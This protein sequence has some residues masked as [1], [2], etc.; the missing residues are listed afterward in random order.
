MKAGRRKINL[1][2]STGNEVPIFRPVRP[3]PVADKPPKEACPPSH[4]GGLKPTLNRC[5]LAWPNMQAITIP[6]SPMCV[7]WV[8]A[9]PY[10]GIPDV[11]VE[12]ESIGRYRTPNVST[13]PTIPSYFLRSDG[14][15]GWIPRNSPCFGLSGGVTNHFFGDSASSAFSSLAF[16]SSTL[17]SSSSS[18]LP[19]SGPRTL[20]DTTSPF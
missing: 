18:F 15:S 12:L 6:A 7:N 5:R 3:S 9:Q 20:S 17:P 4:K 14:N 1:P 19:S 11:R 10:P 8:F 13:W 2:D 16:F